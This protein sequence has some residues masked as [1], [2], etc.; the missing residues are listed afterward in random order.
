MRII[1]AHSGKLYESI[2]TD[3]QVSEVPGLTYDPQAGEAQF[4]NDDT[5][6]P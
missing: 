3:I 4:L 5:R 2:Y 6:D 1:F